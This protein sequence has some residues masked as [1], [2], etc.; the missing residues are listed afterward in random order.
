MA[1]HKMHDRNWT[2]LPLQPQDDPQPRELHPPSTAATLNLAAAA[3]QCA[4]LFAPYDAA[5]ANQCLT[6]A[7]TAYAA[8]KA[9]P[10]VYAEPRPT[11]TAAAPTATTTSPTSS[12]GRRPSSTSPPVTAP[13]GPT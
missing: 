10:A 3:A 4:R 9:N 6:A 2:G 1:H 11:A 7:K 5:F 13:T 12:T 8:A